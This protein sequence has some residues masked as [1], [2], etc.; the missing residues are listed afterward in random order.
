MLHAFGSSDV[1]VI[2]LVG[3]VVVIGLY[4]RFAPKR[5]WSKAEDK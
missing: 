4:L 1:V 3:A 5:D 2:A